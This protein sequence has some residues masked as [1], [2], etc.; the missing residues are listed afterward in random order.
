MKLNFK[1]CVCISLH[2]AAAVSI[3]KLSSLLSAAC[4]VNTLLVVSRGSGMKQSEQRDEKQLGKHFSKPFL[5][6]RRLQLLT[7]LYVC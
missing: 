6:F 5:L 7:D 4:F 2:L 1:Y 3:W